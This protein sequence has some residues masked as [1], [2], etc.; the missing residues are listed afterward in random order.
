M[1]FVARLS[2][3]QITFY[4]NLGIGKT[5]NRML[6]KNDY[7]DV[8]RDDIKGW[9]GDGSLV[10]HMGFEIEKKYKHHNL[11]FKYGFTYLSLAARSYSNPQKKPYHGTGSD[12]V[13]TGQN[14]FGL[15]YSRDFI[16][17]SNAIFKTT[18]SNRKNRSLIFRP[19][20]GI[21]INH[22]QWSG[23]WG[24]TFQI[25]NDT[26]PSDI[27]YG[28]D[29]VDE[30]NKYKA[31]KHKNGFSV[32]TGIR[33][34]YKV[35][36]KEKLSLIFMYNQGITDYLETRYTTYIPSVSKTTSSRF[37][38]NGTFL[39]ICLSVPFKIQNVKGER[40]KDTRLAD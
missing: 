33:V 9:K 40:R 12:I 3:S 5:Y 8:Y 39:S 35:Q 32:E 11:D 14:T 16:L 38:S 23:N 28:W 29:L 25:V 10:I 15:F 26:V 31:V 7:L 18:N 4:P 30:T 27:K 13:G 2:F 34:T 36:N 21:N 17:S 19:Y 22:I 1:F 20:G 24:N 6:D 37:A